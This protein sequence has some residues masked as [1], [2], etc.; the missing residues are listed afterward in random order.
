MNARSFAFAFSLLAPVLAGAQTGPS[1]EDLETLRVEATP[2][3]ALP[4]IALAMP[5]SRNH[6]YW[7]VRIQGG[8]REGR[9]GSDLAAIA[10]GVDF[11][12]RGG[13][14]LGFTAGYQK[15]D[16]TLAGQDCGAHALF[17]ARARINLITGGP[18]IG[19][20]FRD[21]NATSTLGT[22]IGIGYAPKVLPGLNACTVDLGVPVSVAMAQRPRIVTFITPGIVWDMSCSPGGSRTRASYLTGFGIGLQQIKNRSL[23]A[24]LGIQK[25]FRDNTGY[26][27]G[28]SVTYIWLP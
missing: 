22:E 24:F 13:S 6:N 17:G 4:P 8:Q 5:A 28:I 21:Y 18:T 25:I 2:I 27:I 14:V 1:E 19:A 7:G 9:A 20:L 3:G 15:R 16:C 23:D 11:Q 10:A 12:Y 26:Q